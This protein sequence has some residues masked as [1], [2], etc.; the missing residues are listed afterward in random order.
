LLCSF[1]SLLD[2]IVGGGV[3]SCGRVGVGGVGGGWVRR[4][5]RLDSGRGCSVGGVLLTKAG[6]ESKA[7]T[8]SSKSSVD[9]G[10]SVNLKKKSIEGS[11]IE[12]GDI[13]KCNIDTKITSKICRLVTSKKNDG[14]IEFSID[15][16]NNIDSKN[17]VKRGQ[18]GS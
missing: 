14:N 3:D 9:S 2:V 6:S 4:H 16:F 18:T 15:L 7:E 11:N 17:G 13:E 12:Y 5:I 10:S 8:I 1:A